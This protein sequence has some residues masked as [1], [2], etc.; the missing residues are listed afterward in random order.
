MYVGNIR[1]ENCRILYDITNTKS[2]KM[3]SNLCNLI[4]TSTLALFSITY[5][6]GQQVSY[7]KENLPSI[8]KIASINFNDIEDP[9]SVSLVHQ[10]APSVSGNSKK[11]F[12][13]SIKEKVSQLH[14][15]NDERVATTRDDALPPTIEAG[16]LGNNT[17]PGIPLDNTL[18]MNGDQ[19]ISAINFHVAVK[20]PQG[21]VLKNFS[22]AQFAS[23]VG[24][25]GTSFDPRLLYDP[26]AD[27]FILVMLNGFSSTNTDIIVAFS[28]TGDATGI[29]NVYS[30]TGN[31]N[32]NT[33]WTDYPMI[34][35]NTTDLIVTG[36]LIR[37]NETWQAG[38][39][40]TVL[41]QIDKQNGYAGEDLNMVLYKDIEYDGISIRNLCPAESSDEILEPNTYFLSDRNF[42]V[43]S[44]SFFLVELTGGINDDQTALTIELVQSDLPYG[45]PPNAEQR[46]NQLQTNDARVL[47]V[48]YH[49][50]EL[51][52]VGNTRNMT[53]NKAGI[54]HGHVMDLTGT[55]ETTLQHIIGENYEI[56]YPAITYVGTEDGD[57]DVIINFNHTSPDK[58]PGLSAMYWHPDQGYSEI[59][60]IWNGSGYVAMLNGTLQRWGDYS[61]S[62]RDFNDGEACWISGFYG[63]PSLINFPWVAKLRKP[64]GSVN[65][66][67]NDKIETPVS[68]F[69]NP[70]SSRFQVAFDIPQGSKKINIALINN[71]GQLVSQLLDTNVSKYGKTQ[72]SFDQSNLT[73][74]MYH[75]IIQLD[76]KRVSSE[77]IIVE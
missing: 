73:S 70:I 53:N 36:N 14:P 3:G 66:L 12:I 26:E 61:G 64:T 55:K 50:N 74:G 16:F 51:Q 63:A 71:Q 42:S 20:D 32:N 75:L 27:K 11:G 54:F 38:F 45:V 59:I 17:N 1:N 15:K 23:Q 18:A 72:F 6:S 5:V 67:D 57:R 60:D 34:T 49:E 21:N 46:V 48:F 13:A 30:I 69:P 47:E 24:L 35:V 29:W 33:T 8:S 76:Q 68:V 19:I 41:W 22:L 43:E 2:I 4:I 56:G 10:E 7:H 28:A 62:Q 31:P 40:E 37:D 25:S 65:T 58:D 77:K 52:F 9:Y 44:D 39:D